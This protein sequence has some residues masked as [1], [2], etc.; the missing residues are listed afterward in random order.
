MS[1]LYPLRSVIRRGYTRYIIFALWLTAGLAS[2]PNAI[3]VKYWNVYE[4]E[5]ESEEELWVCDTD[6]SLA[7]HYYSLA[8][9]IFQYFLPVGLMTYSY[10]MVATTLWKQQGNIIGDQHSQRNSTRDGNM[11]TG[12]K[13]MIKMLIVVVACYTVCWLPFNIY[14]VIALCLKITQNVAVLLAESAN[15][16]LI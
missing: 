2:I 15:F 14:W 6:V 1:I 4:S 13:K 9:C 10:L 7:F 5:A 12:R 3:Q 8:L 11:L 16:C